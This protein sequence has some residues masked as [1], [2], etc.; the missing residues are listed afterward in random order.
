[1]TVYQIDLVICDQSLVD[2]D[3]ITFVRELRTDSS[4]INVPVLVIA[5]DDEGGSVCIQSFEAGVDDFVQTPFVLG[6]LRARCKRLVHRFMHGKDQDKS[7]LEVEATARE[8]PGIVQY[9]E[10]EVKTGKLTVKCS[11]GTVIVS[12]KDGVFIEATG[13]LCEGTEALTEALCWEKTQ[14]SFLDCDITIPE[15]KDTIKL[16]S[17]LMNCVVDVDEFKEA[18]EK[19]PPSDAMFLPGKPAD[20]EL[21]KDAKSLLEQA[22]NGYSMDEL[23]HDQPFGERVATLT[24]L[25]LIEDGYLNVT[26]PPFHN[27]TKQTY[28]YYRRFHY[29]QRLAAIRSL[30][31]GIAFPLDVQDK[32]LPVGPANWLSPATKLMVVG[33]RGEHM[34]L[35]MDSVAALYR[36]I[37]QKNPPV[38]HPIPKVDSMRMDFG[39]KNVID[40]QKMP[41]VL[42]TRFLKSM[43]DFMED[44]AAVI[45]IATEHT[46]RANQTNLRLIRQVRR[47][48]QGIFYSIVPRIA[49]SHGRILFKIDCH[50]CG[51]RLAVDMNEAGNQG[52]C[53]ICN[54]PLIIPDALDNLAHC[55]QL[56]ND[57]PIILVEP[58]NPEHIRDLL[59]YAIDTIL[60][61]CD[62][63]K[64]EPKVKTSRSKTHIGVAADSEVT[65]NTQ[66]TSISETTI[67][68]ARKDATREDI[69]VEE[70]PDELESLNPVALH[71]L[72]LVGEGSTLDLDDILNADLSPDESDSN[73]L[74][75]DEILQSQDD[76]FDI[77]DFL[78]R[79]R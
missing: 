21:D 27:Y 65:E 57:V 4:F 13:P 64:E 29:K 73:E 33:D 74:D 70:E 69:P 17:V 44:V 52:E 37:T 19:L 56:P 51:Y 55:L 46:R 50:K 41:S 25:R 38:H 53:P 48:F 16:T 68:D 77:D 36:S 2:S 30:Y 72:D 26:D 20:K 39:D 54:A 7:S 14:V 47:R 79:I 49:D 61:A 5:D 75:V 35:F 31:A 24:F 59:L 8:L 71:D 62:P 42:D 60:Y 12:I 23:L 66:E 22:I 18:R 28:S 45:L 58:D 63:P 43:D 10:A 1:M 67:K 32:Q 15:G 76:D 9:L 40:I 3:P 11:K 6:V 78:N 34:Q